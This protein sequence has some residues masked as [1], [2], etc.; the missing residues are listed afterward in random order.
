M[1]IKSTHLKKKKK[2][3][4]D[5]YTEHIDTQTQ[6]LT[7]TYIIMVLLS[8]KFIRWFANI[9]V[10]CRMRL[11]PVCCVGINVNDDR[12]VSTISFFTFSPLPLVIFKVSK[13]S[14]FLYGLLENEFTH[15]TFL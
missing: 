6:K 9:K 15:K 4:L 3:T 12:R 1:Q 14:L 8:S 2:C 13:Y 11:Q 7:Y 5:L 10:Q